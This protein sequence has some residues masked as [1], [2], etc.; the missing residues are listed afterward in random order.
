MSR[1]TLS[2][3]FTLVS[4]SFSLL[5][6]GQQATVA[7]G[8]DGSG[9]GGSISFS[10]GQVGYLFTASPAGGLS[11]G[12]QQ[13]YPEL[14]ISV[15]EIVESYAMRLYPNPTRTYTIL[16]LPVDGAA[17]RAELCDAR[18]RTVAEFAGL[19]EAN[20]L[21]LSAVSSGMYHLRIYRNASYAG[22]FK[23][24]RAD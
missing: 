15:G 3:L 1:H 12:V 4:L 5:A 10:V 20:N 6:L 17:W 7:G 8:G 24:M 2:T 14:D 18:G 9:S 22:H 11:A 21:D 23:V 16:E 19:S 13:T